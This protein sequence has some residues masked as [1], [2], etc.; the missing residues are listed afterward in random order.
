MDKTVYKS[1]LDGTDRTLDALAEL[2]EKLKSID[3][4]IEENRLRHELEEAELIRLSAMR[5]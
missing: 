5:I 3:N 4:L 1:G 2:V